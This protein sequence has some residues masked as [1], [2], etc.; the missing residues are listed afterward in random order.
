MKP[1]TVMLVNPGG[2]EYTG[3]GSTT[4][5]LGLLYLVSD[6]KKNNVPVT[7]IDGCITGKKYILD[8]IK[9]TKP[10]IVGFPVLSPCRHAAWDLLAE[11]KKV[12]DAKVICDSI[13]YP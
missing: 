6:L 4:P 12:S 7:L 11:I 2:T 8:A 3:T 10:D 5:P 13:F 1:S 9:D